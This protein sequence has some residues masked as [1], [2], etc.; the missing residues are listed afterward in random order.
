MDLRGVE[1]AQVIATTDDEDDSILFTRIHDE[2]LSGAEIWCPSENKGACHLIGTHNDSFHNME[3]FV[4]E[5]YSYDYLQID[6]DANISCIPLNISCDGDAGISAVQM[7]YDSDGYE[8]SNG[9]ASFCC[10]YRNC[11]V[12]DDPQM[13]FDATLIDSY[14]NVTELVTQTAENVQSSMEC[15]ESICGIRCEGLLRCAYA[16][17]TTVSQETVIECEGTFSCLGAEVIV[18]DSL[19]DHTVKIIC[20]GTCFHSGISALI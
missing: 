9:N 20:F 6:C 17:I 19:Q 15:T 16:V 2:S 1:T 4:D 14:S 18:D 8:C 7:T 11:S 3:I 5:T 12:F 13:G 10:P